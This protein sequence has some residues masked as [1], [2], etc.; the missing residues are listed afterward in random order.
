MAMFLQS[1]RRGHEPQTLPGEPREVH[2]R[3][4]AGYE[5]D[6]VVARSGQPLRL[7][8]RREDQLVCTEEVVF[9]FFGRS[10]TLPAGE[11]V[12][13]ELLPTEPGVYAFT[14]GWGMLRGL[15]VVTGE[16]ERRFR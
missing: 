3:V 1:I 10:A 16:D 4:R 11:D 6:T 8:F 7:V 2:I 5:P 15:L 14:C 12:S 13:V 9:P